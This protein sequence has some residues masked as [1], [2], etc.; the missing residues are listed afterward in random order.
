[1]LQYLSVTIIQYWYGVIEY[2]D[3][4]TIEHYDILTL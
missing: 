2:L 4:Q 3:I 1:M